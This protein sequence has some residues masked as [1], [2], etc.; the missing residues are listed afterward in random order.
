MRIRLTA[1]AIRAAAKGLGLGQ[2]LYVNLEPDYGLV[3][4]QHFTRRGYRHHTQF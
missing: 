1:K 4:T 2:Q 3:L